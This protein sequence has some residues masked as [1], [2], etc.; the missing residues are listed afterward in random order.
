[1]NSLTS[2]AIMA[3]AAV[4][5]FASGYESGKTAERERMTAIVTQEQIKHAKSV[6]EATN[7]I[8]AASNEY[9][10][11]KSERDRLADRLRRATS[12]SGK[13]DSAGAC[14]ARAARL[15]NMVDGL[16]DLVERCDAG[17][18]GCARRKDALS[19][20]VK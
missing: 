13:A 7:S 19:E 6:A 15:E 3:L 11:V 2:I 5:V 14:E 16:L 8:V 1:M 4:L 10:A 17:W 20:A 12:G 9:D 18:N